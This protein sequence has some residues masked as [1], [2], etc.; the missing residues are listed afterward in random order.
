MQDHLGDYAMLETPKKYVFKKTCIAGS[1]TFLKT[2]LVVE[3]SEDGSA[4][5]FKHIRRREGVVEFHA[6]AHSSD[7]HLCSPYR[8]TERCRG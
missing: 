4:L 1:G 6:H 2:I 3:I 7:Q 8:C 5:N